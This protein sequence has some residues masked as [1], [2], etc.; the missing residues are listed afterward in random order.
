ML[1]LHVMYLMRET[2]LLN[3]VAFLF[4]VLEFPGDLFDGSQPCNQSVNFV[5]GK[6]WKGGGTKEVRKMAGKIGRKEG[7][8][9]GW[10]EGREGGRTDECTERRDE[11]LFLYFVLYH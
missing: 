10:K 5:K 4:E 9:K 8:N 11:E 2:L 6:G 3:N 7:R 1:K